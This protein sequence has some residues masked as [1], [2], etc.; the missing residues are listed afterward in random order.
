MEQLSHPSHDR[1][2][3]LRAAWGQ[4]G[5][6]LSMGTFAMAVH[7]G[8]K[9]MEFVGVGGF[10]A[11]A[12]GLSLIPVNR[13]CCPRCGRVLLRPADSTEFVCDSCG[14]VWSTRCFGGSLRG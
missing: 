13:C 6:M 14:V 10:L 2:T 8:V 12:A 9:W 5:A 11:A 3:G 1:A 4:A 7:L